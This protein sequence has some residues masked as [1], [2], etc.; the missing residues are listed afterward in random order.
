VSSLPEGSTLTVKAVVKVVSDEDK[1]GQCAAF[2][3]E[4]L[5]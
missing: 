5:K 2:V 3:N 4:L 1:A